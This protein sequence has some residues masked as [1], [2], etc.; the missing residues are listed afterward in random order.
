MSVWKNNP[1]FEW[2]FFMNK[3]ESIGKGFFFNVFAK[4]FFFATAYAVYIVLGKILLTPEQFGTYGV[5]VYAFSIVDAVLIS[6]FDQPIAKFV[7][8][9]PKNSERILSK[10]LRS[11][12]LLCIV[13]FI[14]LFFSSPLI[15][16]A[17][18]DASLAKYFQIFSF[19]VLFM[20]AFALIEGY[21][22]G[23]GRFVSQAKLN[24]M[25]VGMR[26]LFIVGFA[27]FLLPLGLAL[28]GAF[29]GFVIASSLSLLVAWFFYGRVPKED[30]S[31]SNLIKFAVP[32]LIF[33]IVS[34]I[35][36]NF[37]IL[38]VKALS[39][40]ALSSFFAGNFLVA[41][42]IARIP[43]FFVLA[44]IIVLFPVISSLNAQKNS[45]QVGFV[46]KKA[47]RYSLVFLIPLAFL[48]AV[49]PNA[50]V[51]FFYSSKYSAAFLVLPLLAFSQLFYS[52]FLIFSSIVA[53]VNKP[54][55]SVYAAI[56]VLLIDIA[57]NI[58]LIPSIGF[59]G[60]GY[61]SLVSSIIGFLILLFFVQ[62]EFGFVISLFSVV[63]IVTASLIAVFPFVFFK[64]FGLMLIPFGFFAA[65]VFFA[66]LFVL[67]ELSAEDIKFFQRVFIKK[68]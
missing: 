39:E 67:R 2:F 1:C 4:L 28:E 35:I 57:L 34:S 18:N 40:K 37:D 49:V 15:A 6:V 25:Y 52:L 16:I 21:L 68:L 10:C 51:N 42:T 56:V 65:I 61:A 60:V 53:G 44:L 32:I 55:L 14:V 46:I 41:I 19:F 22:N 45:G 3:N 27:F 11:Q 48:I 13:V 12:I 31:L 66:V 54:F 50:L 64:P 8:A 26:M 33:S 23:R 30:Y 58:V 24:I 9:E 29:F 38:A 20:P 7:S 17:L 47:M 5:V 59:A 43:H 36:T 63:R 62:R